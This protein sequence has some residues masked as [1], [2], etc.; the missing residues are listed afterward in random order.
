MRRLSLLLPLL[1][2]CR[3]GPTAPR[4]FDFRISESQ[5]G[6]FLE[7]GIYSFAGAYGGVWAPNPPTVT[8]T[9]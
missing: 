7:P 6:S 3:D 9:F 1:A 5:F 4:V 8:L 2:A